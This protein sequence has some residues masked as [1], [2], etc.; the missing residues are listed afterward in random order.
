MNV[1][2][3]ERPQQIENARVTVQYVNPKEGNRRSAN[4]KDTDGVI[5]WIKPEDIGLF[6]PG[7]TYDI[8]FSV[9]QSQSGYT[10]RNVRHAVPVQPQQ[11][12]AQPRAQAQQ[13][14]QPVRQ[15]APIEP[16]H[17]GNGGGHQFKP[18]T[19]DEQIWVCACIKS[20]IEMGRVGTS[21][22]EI[23]ERV[24]VH[25]SVWQRTFGSFTE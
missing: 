18:P 8:E 25:R 20:D 6:T 7:T 14:R 24:N 16:Q 2:T 21:E 15:S 9:T 4:I 23:V 3:M 19:K 13:A 22:D 5:Y 17:G 10:N 1:A 11:R 12:Q